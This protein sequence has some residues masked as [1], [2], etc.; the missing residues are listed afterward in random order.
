[1][2]AKYSKNMHL[3][4]TAAFVVILAGCAQQEIVKKEIC[5][6]SKNLH[7]IIE[8]LAVRS[9]QAKPIR[10]NGKMTYTGFV[11][12]KKEAKENL[13]IRLRFFPP[14]RLYLRANS[15]LGEELC[16]G[17]NER[18]FWVRIKTNPP[19]AYWFGRRDDMAGCG[20]S[21]F[22]GPESL[23]EAVG[24]IDI[25]GNWQLEVDDGMDVLVKTGDGGRAVKKIYIDR[26]TDLPKKIEYL[27]QQGQIVLAIEMADFTMGKDSI[28]VP[29]EISITSF[30]DEQITSIIDITLTNIKLFTPTGA[31]L[32]GKLFKLPSEDSVKNVFELDKNC[33]FVQK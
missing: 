27:G 4:Y 20:S 26:C 31:L 7:Q 9:E 3:F 11:D 14:D 19:S 22:L 16:V 2:A 10:T 21:L 8:H 15:I 17:M 33:Q 1:M 12:G 25:M 30:E 5:P 13:D 29:A 28:V 18:D 23:L 32:E 6:P 24:I